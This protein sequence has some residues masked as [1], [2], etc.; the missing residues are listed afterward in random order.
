MKLRNKEPI[1]F[2]FKRY[3]K[4]SKKNRSLVIITIIFTIIANFITLSVPIVYGMLL[5]HIQNNVFDKAS[6]KIALLY[7]FALFC[8]GIIYW[9]FNWFARVFERK[10]AYKLRIAY[11]NYLLN[12]IL[13][14]DMSWHNN[15]KS[16]DII[17]KVNKSTEGL[18]AFSDYFSNIIS[19][20]VA[21]VGS[22]IMLVKFNFHLS[23]IVLIFFIS[24]FLMILKFDSK[25]IKSHKKINN[26]ENQ[27]AERIFDNISNITTV[28]ILKIE[29]LVLRDVNKAMWKSEREMSRLIKRIET[30]WCLTDI[31]GKF[32]EFI[33]LSTYLLLVYYN[34]EILLVGT[35]TTL[36]LYIRNIRMTFFNF[37]AR[38]GTYLKYKAQIENI[39]EVEKCFRDEL[40]NYLKLPKKW[41]KIDIEKLKFSY[42]VE[43]KRAKYIL[44]NIY[45]E[46]KR[47]EKIAIIGESG[48]GK[49]TFLKLLRGLYDVSD[50]D[51]L[52]DYERDRDYSLKNIVNNTMLI[53]QEP[54]LFARTIRENITMD[55]TFKD[56]EIRDY[57]DLARFSGVLDKLPNGF[58][59]EINEK[60]V[61]LSGGEK[62]RLALARALLFSRDKDII[63]MD[64]STS[65]VDSKNEV[66]IYR[67]VFR[68]F[69]DKTFIATIHKLNLLKEFDRIVIFDNGEVVDNGSFKDLILRNDKFKRDWEDYVKKHK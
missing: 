63:L 49:T 69:K 40:I 4:F 7:V 27:V 39:E 55:M 2:L 45:F 12:G 25:I 66:L 10:N 17:D 52:I 19:V 47:G 30:K 32:L 53:P 41:E 15:H 51:V 29:K 5:N 61:N 59:S 21:F 26:Y 14:L 42:D 31:L 1:L 67:N 35:F 38:Y 65:S 11:K 18:Y 33:A 13:N 22:Y 23:Y 58:D 28:L 50:V 8:L 3:W 20:I 57:T 34:N 60:G 64:E 24:I 48:S 44:K 6:L 36:Y 62:Q 43:S 46:I 9:F 54:E 68:K 56:D 37:T 16:G